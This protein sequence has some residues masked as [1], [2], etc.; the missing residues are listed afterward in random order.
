LQQ[1]VQSFDISQCSSQKISLFNGEVKGKK[2]KKESY[3]VQGEK[4]MRN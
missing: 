2:I 1:E 4:E 3:E